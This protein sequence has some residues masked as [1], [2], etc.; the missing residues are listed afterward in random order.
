MASSTEL[1]AFVVALVALGISL[2][3][4]I[5]QYMATSVLRSKIGRA[6]IGVWADTKKKSGFDFSEYKIRAT[7]LEPTLTWERVEECLQRQSRDQSAILSQLRDRYSFQTSVS[8][9]KMIAQGAKFAEPQELVLRPKSDRETQHTVPSN[10]LPRADRR[11]VQ[12]INGSCA[13]EIGLVGRHARQLGANMMAAKT[14]TVSV[15]K[16]LYMVLTVFVSV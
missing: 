11:L 7:Y 2:L 5:Q 3:Q 13:T 8:V 9:W 16:C 6:V 12:N 15:Y 10:S 14:P 1:T 4:F